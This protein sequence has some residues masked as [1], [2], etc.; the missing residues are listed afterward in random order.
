LKLFIDASALVAILAEEADHVALSERLDDAS[1][2]Y[3]SA[4]SCWETINALRR[5]RDVNFDDARDTVESFAVAKGFRMVSVGEDER[6]GALYAYRTYGR[7]RHAARLNMG[8]CFAYACA[9]A[10]DAM[11]L[12]KGNDFAETDLA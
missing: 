4:M 5:S 11:L 1:E 10:V 9:K 6:T 12:Y 8:D 2:R 3:W 7:G